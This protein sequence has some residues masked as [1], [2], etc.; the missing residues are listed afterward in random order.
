MIY[1]NYNINDVNE[2]IYFSINLLELLITKFY[3]YT[4][5]I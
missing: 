1:K 3:E 2:D 4:L 5:T